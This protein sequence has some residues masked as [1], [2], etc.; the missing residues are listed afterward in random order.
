MNQR[1]KEINRQIEKLQAEKEKL[2]VLDKLPLTERKVNDY[3]TGTYSGK[4]L[5]EKHSLSENG[6]WHVKGEDPNCDLGG[7]H[8]Q[9]DLG[10]VEGTLKDALNYAVTHPRFYAWGGGGDIIKIQIIKP[11]QN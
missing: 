7:S 8:V 4:R 10:I 3:L 9:P 11:T 5:L 1:I 2:E 6:V